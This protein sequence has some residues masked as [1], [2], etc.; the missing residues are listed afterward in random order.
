V[1]RARRGE[2]LASGQGADNIWAGSAGG[3]VSYFHPGERNLVFADY[4]GEYGM[5][6]RD[7]SL[8]SLDQ[9][10]SLGLARKLAPRWTFGLMGEGDM[11]SAGARLFRTSSQS[12][13]LRIGDL[14]SAT[15]GFGD[16]LDPAGLDRSSFGYGFLLGGSTMRWSSSATLNFNKSERTIWR[17]SGFGTQTFYTGRD[18]VESAGVPF[19]RV[20]DVMGTLGARYSLSPRTSIGFDFSGGRTYS[21]VINYERTQTLA[22]WGRRLSPAWFANVGAGFGLLRSNR[23]DV[24]TPWGKEYLGHG[25][26]G[27]G[28]RENSILF[29]VSRQVGDGYGFGFATTN[30]ASVAW[31]YVPFGSSWGFSGSVSGQQLGGA[32]YPRIRGFMGMAGLSKRL[33]GDVHLFLELAQA[34]AV[35]FGANRLFPTGFSSSGLESLARRAA[36]LSLVYAPLPDRK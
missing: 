12:Q 10:F 35:G 33:S 6:P 28:G 20:T 9:L 13:R 11:R 36:R 5:A 27:Y 32:G 23:T 8:D 22:F 18:R 7:S 2:R 30:F 29:T 14:S 16:P 26:L 19:S 15:V 25:T 21:G 34:T 17:F 1:L 4:G 31:S 24:R 3:R